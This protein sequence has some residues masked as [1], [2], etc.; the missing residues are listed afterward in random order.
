MFFHRPP[1]IPDPGQRV[2][3]LGYDEI[4][5]GGFWAVSEPFTST[6]GEVVMR[7]AEEGEYRAAKRGNRPAVGVIWPIERMRV[8]E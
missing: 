3:L 4:W 5:R 2:M 6:G 1:R 8:E 7:V